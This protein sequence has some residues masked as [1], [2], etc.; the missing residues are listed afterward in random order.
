M[1][2]ICFK[3]KIPKI[4]SDCFIASNATVFGDAV[5]GPESSGWLGTVIRGDVFDVRIGQETNIKDNSVGHV[6]TCKYS[7]NIGNKVTIGHWVI[8]HGWTINDHVLIGIGSIMLDD[9][10]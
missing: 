2:I 8:L 6:T 7:T 3:N 1:P 4:S 9:S 5:I 10:E